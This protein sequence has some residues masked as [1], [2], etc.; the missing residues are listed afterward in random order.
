MSTSDEVETQR[1]TAAEQDQLFAA[2]GHIVVNFQ[3]VELWLAE[4]LTSVLSL[5]VLEDRHII[6][7]AMSFRQKVDLM[8][9]LYPRKKTHEYG[10]EIKLIKKALN[11]AEEFRNRIVH[12]VWAVEF[13]G[14]WVRVKSNIKGRNGFSLVTTPASIAHLE[15]AAK[16]LL[17]IREWEL[18]NTE[19][20]ESAISILSTPN[21]NA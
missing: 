16:A 3:Q 10:V 6:S 15:A 14:K 12:S 11:T 1:L 19:N 20:L 17:T 21:T 18:T 8:A 2:I 13:P 4:A 9:E 7:S 5:R